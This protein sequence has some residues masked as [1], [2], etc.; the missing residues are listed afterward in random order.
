M[1][2]FLSVKMTWA[3]SS[4]LAS[5]CVPVVT[6]LYLGKQMLIGLDKYFPRYG[7]KQM[8]LTWPP[9][10]N[11]SLELLPGLFE[12]VPNVRLWPKADIRHHVSADIDG[13]CKMLLLQSVLFLSRQNPRAR[14]FLPLINTNSRVSYQGSV[15]IVTILDKF[16]SSISLILL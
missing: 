6:F 11:E 5:K 16:D 8:R 10:S 4:S 9:E 1:G 7:K 14:P 2:L 13:V 3:A 12:R 15:E